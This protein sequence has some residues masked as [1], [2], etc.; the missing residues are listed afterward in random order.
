MFDAVRAAFHDPDTRQYQVLN[1][2][3]WALIVLSIL[4]VFAELVHPR[5]PDS[6]LEIVDALIVGIFSVELALRILTFEPPQV[7]FYQ[8]GPA[9]TMR[10][11]IIGR[12]R[13][14]ATSP[15]NLIDFICVMEVLHPAFRGLRAMRALRLFRGLGIF[16]YNSPMVALERALL[17][18]LALYVGAFGLLFAGVAVGGISIF[19]TNAGANPLIRNVWDGMWWALVTITTVGYG[20]ISPD[21]DDTVGRA[22][23]A[24]LMIF[25][26]VMLAMF[27][28]II[29]NSLLSSV[30]ALRLE[31]FRMTNTYRH[32]VVCGYNE[33]ARMLLD[34]LE[35]EVDSSKREV[36]IFGKGERPA[37]I[38]HEYRWVEGDPTKESELDKA[39]I[40]EAS[41]VI[42]VGERQLL[43]QSADAQTILTAFTIRRYL[44]KKAAVTPRAQPLYVVAEVLDHENI[45]HAFA[46]GCDEVIETTRL[47]FSLISHAISHPGT[48][49][50]LG[51]LATSDGQNLYVGRIPDELGPDASFKDAVKLLADQAIL[52][53]G[54]RNV[55]GSDQLNPLPDT[56]LAGATGLIYIAARPALPRL[57]G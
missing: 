26:M 56:R 31:Q 49:A 52:V 54:L 22:V 6:W 7:R 19:M 32:I 17:D 3:I 8:Q 25:G 53:V 11:Q 12:I 57:I 13:Y 55:G 47:G 34:A 36:V 21:P 35:E 15:R 18:N 48:G 46:A 23:A 28:G 33:G 14:F 1:T 20:D 2:G 45:E 10:A 29:S 40:P 50:L 9:A 5:G 16:R 41:A 39:R 42:V 37:S 38:P 43:P 4:L 30:L 51:M 27:A 24:A 44:K